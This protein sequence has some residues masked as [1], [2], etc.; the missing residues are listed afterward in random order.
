[1]IFD[2]ACGVA[3]KAEGLLG[4]LGDTREFGVGGF[5]QESNGLG[6]VGIGA[7]EVDEVGDGLEGVVDLVGDGGGKAAVAASFSL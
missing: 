7:G 4:D 2:G 6:D 5:E 3:V 1:M